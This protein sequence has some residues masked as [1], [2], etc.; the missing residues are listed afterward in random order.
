MRAAFGRTADDR[1]LSSCNRFQERGRRRIADLDRSVAAQGEHAGDF[2]R[3]MLESRRGS[4]CE[5]RVGV[6]MPLGDAC[7][8][9][10]GLG[11]DAAC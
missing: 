8:C 2:H 6:Q 3:Q 9:K 5:S 4:Q 11:L 10:C 7:S 1:D